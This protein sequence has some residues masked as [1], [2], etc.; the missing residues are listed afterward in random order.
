MSPRIL[1]FLYLLHE[2]RAAVWWAREKAAAATGATYQRQ[3]ANC[4]H[5]YHATR[6]QRLAALASEKA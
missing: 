4:M 3:L 2:W 1:E 5:T 6:T